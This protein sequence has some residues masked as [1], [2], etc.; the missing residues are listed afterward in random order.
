MFAAKVSAHLVHM[1]FRGKAAVSEVE[2]LGQL[3]AQ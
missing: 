3:S 2:I 1:N